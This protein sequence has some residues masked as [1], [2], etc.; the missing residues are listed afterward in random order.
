MAD[1][2][3]S[4]TDPKP[5]NPN[6]RKPN[7]V[8]TAAIAGVVLAGV[9]VIIGLYLYGSK[10]FERLSAAEL[11]NLGEKYLL[12]MNYEQAV[13]NFTRL[14]EVEP[15]NPRGYVGLAEAYAGLGDIDK[16]IEILRQGLEEL[17]DDP[18]ILKML[19][20][21]LS[22]QEPE[23]PA[24]AAEYTV[25][26]VDYDG[27]VLKNE[28]VTEGEAVAPPV[29]PSREG[30]VFSGWDKAYN[31]VTGDLTVTAQYME[32]TV[33]AAAFTATFTDYDG[34]V[35]KT[36]TV[37]DGE[38]ATP[39]D[40]P[41]R[42]GYTFTGWD[43]A[44]DNVT[45]DLS[46]TAQ[47]EEAEAEEVELATHTVTFA[48]Y[49]GRVLKAETVNS[50]KAATPPASP[51]REGYSF[52]GWDVRFDNVTTDLTVTAVYTEDAQI[53]GDDITLAFT[54]PIFLA[55]VRKIIKK[56]T[57][58]I[59][60]SDV[61]GITELDFNNSLISSLT[62]IEYFTALTRLSCWGNQLTTLDVSHNTALTYLDCSYNQLTM[63]DVS[64]NPALT[65][66]T[67][68][69]NRLT[70]LDVSNNPE[71][72]KLECWSNQLTALDVSN[73]PAL[74]TLQCEINKMSDTTIEVKGWQS[75]WGNGQ[76]AGSF[77]Y[78]PQYP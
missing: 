57:G 54:D 50:G 27:T 15:R 41:S 10:P 37:T 55:T 49:D 63:L 16:A 53:T 36:E 51:S 64:N 62:G 45:E 77:R 42:E 13:V 22:E 2:G 4:K 17:P 21:L 73:S 6:K 30:Y 75:A 58:S 9:V 67:C 59:Y 29:D 69:N 14:I 8:M 35:I 19:N 44:F 12:E 78:F 3:I 11:L 33:E 68:D 74:R 48:D 18:N 32:V 20:E 5:K 46:I 39:P 1:K 24:Q 7:A 31:N 23:P 76:S 40:D 60:K 56:P 66:L 72:T 34:T 61:S 65:Y 26:F 43:K 71:L 38:A 25:T 70:M 47:Y 52:T 28:T